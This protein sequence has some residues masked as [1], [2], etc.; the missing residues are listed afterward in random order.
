MDDGESR[1]DPSGY[2]LEKLTSRNYYLW[3]CK[4]EVLLRGKGLWGIVSGTEKRPESSDIEK[5]NKYQRRQDL[6]L[7][8]ILL[9]IDDSVSARVLR[10][11]HPKTEWDTLS[12]MF[13]IVSEA[14]VDSYLQKYQNTKMKYNKEVMQYVNRL[15]DL[16]NMLASV[17]HSLSEK[18]RKRALLRGLRD[19]FQVM[20]KV[21][22]VTNSSIEDAISQLVL[23][24]I[25]LT[26]GSG[27]TVQ[28]ESTALTTATRD[29]RRC[30]YCS[31]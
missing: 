6:A 15:T 9:C 22:T 20:R 28:N 11:R 5:V 30:H 13:S 31:G 3:S 16:E 27:K 21:L 23:E 2:R 1:V 18:E 8:N 19:E 24:E 25:S 26:E 7:T 10:L 14:S 4:M 29:R 17:G 12:S